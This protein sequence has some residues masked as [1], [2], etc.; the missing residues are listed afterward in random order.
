MAKETNEMENQQMTAETS[1]I[2]PRKRKKNTGVIVFF[3]IFMIMVLGIAGFIFRKPINQFLGSQLKDV[4]VVGTLFKEEGAPKETLTKTQLEEQLASNQ[5][6][7][8]KLNE[9][10]TVLQE[11]KVALESKIESLK[12]Y[13]T[14]YENFLAQKE[15]WD[16]AI[17]KTN[18]DMFISQFEQMYPETA[19]RLYN[20]IKTTSLET[21]EQKAFSKTIA[22]MDEAQAAKALEILIPT[23]PELIQLIFENMAKDRQSLILSNMTSQGAAQVIKLVSPPI[24]LTN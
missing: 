17:A 16:E 11:E 15:E 19:E 9:M 8:K 5:A 18:V 20:E 1:F 13:E 3:L 23:D 2:A 4:P 10:V 24:T 12:E 22:E 21:K 14:N 6:E 7:I